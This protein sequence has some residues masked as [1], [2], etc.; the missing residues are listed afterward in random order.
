MGSRQR[1]KILKCRTGIH[2]PVD[3]R[4]RANDVGMSIF[5]RLLKT[6]RKTHSFSESVVQA[7]CC[8]N[9]DVQVKVIAGLFFV[10][11]FVFLV[12]G[13][14]LRYPIF[15]SYTNIDFIKQLNKTGLLNVSR[16]FNNN[17]SV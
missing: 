5:E 13:N 9:S 2:R 17:S 12:L 3:R 1:Q 4:F 11:F 16:E 14:V 10:A 7:E 6:K 8:F 15:D